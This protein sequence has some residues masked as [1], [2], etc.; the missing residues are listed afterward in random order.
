[1]ALFRFD[2]NGD[3]IWTKTYSDTANLLG[4]YVKNTRNK[5]YIVGAVWDSPVYHYTP[6]LSEMDSLGN[7]LWQK[8]YP[9]TSGFKSYLSGID[10]CKDEGF[11]MSQYNYDSTYAC[12]DVIQITKTDSEGTIQWSKNIS[13][14]S[15]C[16][17]IPGGV[18]SLKNGGYLFCGLIDTKSTYPSTNPLLLMTKLNNMGNVLWQKT[19]G[20]PTGNAGDQALMTPYELANGDIIACGNIA[21]NNRL[22]G[23]ILKTDSSGNLL[24]LRNDSILSSSEQNYLIDI[25]PTRDGGYISCGFTYGS[26]ENMWVVKTDSLGCA[27]STGCVYTGV[28]E[29]QKTADAYTLYPN[30]SNGRFTIASKT[31]LKE[32]E[33]VEIYNMLGQKIYQR[34]LNATTT[35]IDINPTAKGIYLYRILSKKNVLISQGKFVVE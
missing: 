34:K 7:R 22:I 14:A 18:V 21:I 5:R 19:Y 20:I 8:T 9:A 33:Y 30:P 17:A 27:D 28:Q 10:T 35:N 29:F 16:D 6:V 4:W 32:D 23:C 1:M 11:I 25:T 2:N 31:L 15:L 12:T 26:T 24:W 3:T 13:T